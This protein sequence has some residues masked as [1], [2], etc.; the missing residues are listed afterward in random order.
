[1]NSNSAQLIHD[2][3]EEE[4]KEEPVS[5]FKR[6][7]IGLGFLKKEE[8]SH[9]EEQKVF[10]GDKLFILESQYKLKSSIQEQQELI[11]F[12]EIIKQDQLD[13]GS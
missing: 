2:N 10:F 8:N 7:K 3:R 4:K 6:I 1:M 12:L 13:H 5:V 9:K 11:S